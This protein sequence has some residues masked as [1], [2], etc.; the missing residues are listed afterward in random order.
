M[1]EGRFGTDANERRSLVE[2]M[3]RLQASARTIQRNVNEQ[4]ELATQARE[5]LERSLQSQLEKE[6]HLREEQQE[7]VQNTIADQNTALSAKI[8]DMKSG[9]AELERRLREGIAARDRDGEAGQARRADELAKQI[10][11]LR[12]STRDDLAKEREERERTT[13]SIEEH[14]SAL[15]HFLQ[16]VGEHLLGNALRRARSTSMRAYSMSQSIPRAIS[17]D[18][19]RD[20]SSVFKLPELHGEKQERLKE[21]LN[22]NRVELSFNSANDSDPDSHT[23]SPAGASIKLKKTIDFEPVH[24]G[25]SPIACFKDEEQAMRVLA[26]VAEIMKLY[27]TASLLIEGHTAT[28]D[29]K[30]DK[31]AQELAQ[32]RADKV[33][34][35]LLSLDMEAE[36]L[37][38]V[39][40]P[41]HHGSGKHDVLLKIANF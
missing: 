25:E 12:D 34:S 27:H 2:D 17:F 39:G 37:R 19:S 11:Q 7:A 15:D 38:A 5:A 29:E 16:D 41:G 35:T 28:P 40:R 9:L 31:W 33:R 30:V 32:S 20:A 23:K 3:E 22:M 6:C 18:G 13:I 24:H 26:D 1:G 36:R 10:R 8:V 4:S 14:I 21:I